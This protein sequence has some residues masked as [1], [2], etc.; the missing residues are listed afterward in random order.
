MKIIKNSAL[1]LGLAFDSEID[2]GNWNSEI[3]D[4]ETLLIE[5]SCIEKSTKEN[6]TWMIGQDETPFKGTPEQFIQQQSSWFKKAFPNPLRN[7]EGNIQTN[8]HV[9]SRKLVKDFFDEKMF[10]HGAFGVGIYTSPRKISLNK[11]SDK[12]LYQL[13]INSN[14]PQNRLTP[15]DFYEVRQEYWALQDKYF[16]AF[17]AGNKLEEENFLEKLEANTDLYKNMIVEEN[18]NKEG[19]LKAGFDSFSPDFSREY[20]IP[21][22][23]FPKS[24]VGNVGF[25]DMANPNIFK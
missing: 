19:H 14:N 5:Y 1:P 23:N 18:K 15:N 13:Y 25:F 16:K 6:G 9:S 2:W 21:F 8:Y 3:L 24:T 7:R 10:K 17:R 20:I 11:G 22:S 12:E 4:H